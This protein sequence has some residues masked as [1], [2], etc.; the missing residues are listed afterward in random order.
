MRLYEGTIEQFGTDVM[1]SKISDV[2][3]KNYEES[4]GRKVNKSELNSW[5]NS[6]NFL[7]NVIDYSQLK[8]NYIVVEYQIPYSSSRIDVL[9]FGKDEALRGNIVVIELKQWSNDNVG[10]CEHGGNVIVNYG[11][12]KR[13][14]EHPCLQVQGYHY[15]LTDFVAVFEE[16]PKINLSSCA[17]CHNYTR[18]PTNVLCSLKFEKYIE[19][20]PLFLREDIKELGIYLNKR[21]KTGYGLDV[22][23]RFANS[24]LKPSKKLLEHTK[25]M[26]NKQQIFNL[27]DDQIPAYNAIMHMAMKSSSLKK[28]SVIIVKGAPVLANP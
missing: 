1:L 12:S 27:I 15:W 8:D 23:N 5:N 13:E 19:K 21:L 3:S 26:M 17:Y 14:C 16:Y 24:P 25:D 6:L 18:E 4:V 20:Y 10:D 28:K 11:K 22:F 2:L 9:L 7:K